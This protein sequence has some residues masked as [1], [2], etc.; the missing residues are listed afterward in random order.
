[1]PPGTVGPPSWAVGTAKEEDAGI[2]PRCLRDPDPVARHQVRLDP[3]LGERGA[4]ADQVPVGID[5]GAFPELVRRIPL[6]AGSCR[7]FRAGPIPRKGVRVLDVEIGLAA[8][9]G[10]FV[11]GGRGQMQPDAVPFGERVVVALF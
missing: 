11:V 4:E 2:E 1:M 7:R 6:A 8:V 3:H 9:G 5:M 10:G